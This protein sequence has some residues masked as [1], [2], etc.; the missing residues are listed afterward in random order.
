MRDTQ[1]ERQKHRQKEKQA[2]CGELD[3]GVDPR[4]PESQP[5]PEADAQPLK[6]LG[7]PDWVF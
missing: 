6:H 7:A 5:E 1:R 2:S 4:T 3:V